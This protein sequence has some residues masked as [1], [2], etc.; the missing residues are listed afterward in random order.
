KEK[1]IID[2]AKEWIKNWVGEKKDM[3]DKARKWVKSLVA[4]SLKSLRIVVLM[5]PEIYYIISGFVAL[6]QRSILH[7][8]INLFHRIFRIGTMLLISLRILLGCINVV[9][10]DF[11]AQ[12]DRLK[13]IKSLIC[14]KE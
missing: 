13:E 6:Q 7:G 11:A 12:D 9:C 3:F 14:G 10:L 2:K 4:I 1:I 5:F 8:I